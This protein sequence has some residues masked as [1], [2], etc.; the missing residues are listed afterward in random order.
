MFDNRIRKKENDAIKESFS[1]I[2]EE[3]NE[4]KSKEKVETKKIISED[5]FDTQFDKLLNLKLKL[6]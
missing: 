6:K 4:D 3:E 1:K 5:M 2:I